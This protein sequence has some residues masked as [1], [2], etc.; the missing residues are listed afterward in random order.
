MDANKFAVVLP[1]I[2]GGLVNKIIDET[3][4]NDDEAFE[5]LYNTELYTELAREETKLWTYSVPMLYKLYQ[6]NINSGTLEL[7]DY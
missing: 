3:N 5:K 4:I 1:I 6:E 7:A 2:I